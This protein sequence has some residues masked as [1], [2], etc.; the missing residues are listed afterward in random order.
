LREL[1]MVILGSVPVCI[2]SC[3]L[4][5]AGGLFASLTPTVKLDVPAGPLG[6]PE[7]TPL[8]G[9]RPRPAGSDPEVIE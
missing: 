6:V 2:D 5:L 7:M 9:S 4:A 3:W 8:S 1:L